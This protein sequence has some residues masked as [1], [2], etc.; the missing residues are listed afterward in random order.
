MVISMSKKK[1][2]TKSKKSRGCKKTCNKSCNREKVCGEPM[3]V[4]PLRPVSEYYN[5]Q[6]GEIYPKI[7]FRESW[8]TKL[9]RFIGLIP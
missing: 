5:L 7:F 2:S 9:K 3:P 8:W 4:K 6:T 1:K